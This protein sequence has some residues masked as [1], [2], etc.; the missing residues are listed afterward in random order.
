MGAK[1]KPPS[2]KTHKL[3]Y[4]NVDLA[5]ALFD[6]NKSVGIHDVHL[7]SGWLL[8]ARRVLVPLVPRLGRERRNEIRLRRA[9]LP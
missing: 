3:P 6:Q 7:P 8:N 9:I 5:H 2:K 4:L 1:K